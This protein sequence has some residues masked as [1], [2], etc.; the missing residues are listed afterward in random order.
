MDVLAFLAFGAVLLVG[1]GLMF[2]GQLRN[3]VVFVLAG[4]FGCSLVFVSWYVLLI[5]AILRKD[6]GKK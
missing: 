2:E 4:L 5:A 6:A 1:L 3:A